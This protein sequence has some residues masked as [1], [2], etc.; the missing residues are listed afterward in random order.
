MND[1]R[2]VFCRKGVFIKAP[3]TALLQTFP[4]AAKASCAIYSIIGRR[5][6][7]NGGRR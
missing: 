6:Q 5:T 4:L 1:S 2:R 7:E 3:A